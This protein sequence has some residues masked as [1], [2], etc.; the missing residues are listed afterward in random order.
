MEGVAL[1][2]PSDKASCTLTHT[3][4][5]MAQP[6]GGGQGARGVVNQRVG[7]GGRDQL[8]GGGRGAWPAQRRG[9]GGGPQSRKARW[10]SGVSH[11]HTVTQHTHTHKQARARTSTSTSTLM[12][13]QAHTHTSTYIHT[14]TCA[15]AHTCTSRHNLSRL[16]T[17]GPT[18]SH[19]AT[20]ADQPWVTHVPTRSHLATPRSHKVAHLVDVRAP[21]LEVKP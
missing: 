20:L 10:W 3:H 12:H 19:L 17:L 14:H 13:T 21:S 1:D 11:D 5:C 15:H 6:E 4:T 9:A 2:R 16:V 7:A 8:E 18:W